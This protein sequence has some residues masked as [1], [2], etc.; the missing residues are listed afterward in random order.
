MYYANKY[1][2]I[3]KNCSG[4]YIQNLFRHADPVMADFH[5]GRELMTNKHRRKNNRS[6]PF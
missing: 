1:I 6:S 3:T 5:E 2:E 4:I